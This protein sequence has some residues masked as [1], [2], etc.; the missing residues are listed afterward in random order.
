MS[1]NADALAIADD[2]LA[3]ADASLEGAILAVKTVL[4]MVAC[5][6]VGRPAP[7]YS[8]PTLERFNSQAFAQLETMTALRVKIAEARTIGE[9][10]AR[11]A[12]RVH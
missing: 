12:R 6:L 5:H 8:L 7:D 4:R 9:S 10:N 2:A 1:S 3:T 11:S